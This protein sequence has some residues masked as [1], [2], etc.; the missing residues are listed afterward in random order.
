MYRRRNENLSIGGAKVVQIQYLYINYTISEIYLIF[1][2]DDDMHSVWKALYSLYGMPKPNEDDNQIHWEAVT[3][4]V[5]ATHK[6]RTLSYI[7]N[8]FSEKCDDIQS[9]KVDEVR[10]QL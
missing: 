5:S 10:R 9:R 8:D 6:P 4:H 3:F 7:I 1:D 2:N